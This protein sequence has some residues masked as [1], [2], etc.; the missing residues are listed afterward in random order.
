M[1]FGLAALGRKDAHAQATGSSPVP[2]YP[3]D[4]LPQMQKLAAA[5]QCGEHLPK[6]PYLMATFTAKARSTVL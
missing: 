1:H 5:G 4:L 2:F 3:S 6:S